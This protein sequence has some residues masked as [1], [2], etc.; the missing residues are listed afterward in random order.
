MI[1]EE[2]NSDHISLFNISGLDQLKTSAMRQVLESEKCDVSTS[3]LRKSQWYIVFLGYIML[4]S[5][6]EIIDKRELAVAY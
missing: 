4:H 6:K 5:D 1:V 3:A 2:E